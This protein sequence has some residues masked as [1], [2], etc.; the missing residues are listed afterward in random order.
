M[1]VPCCAI[2]A[3]D[4]RTS[5]PETVKLVMLVK[6]S[7]LGLKLKV[8]G[9]KESGLLVV[10]KGIKIGWVSIPIKTVVKVGGAVEYAI[11][12]TSKSCQ[13][14]ASATSR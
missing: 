6:G 9:F 13:T 7:V 5:P 4:I 3:P 14:L 2:V 8:A 11:V 1:Y 10:K 12:K